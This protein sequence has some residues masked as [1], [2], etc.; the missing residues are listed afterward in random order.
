MCA[1][2]IAKC[3]LEMLFLNADMNSQPSKTQQLLP[4]FSFEGGGGIGL[5]S[6]P[7]P[8]IGRPVPHYKILTPNSKMSAV[9]AI[10][11]VNLISFSYNSA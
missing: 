5:N 11:Q 2:A 7:P 8:P 1:C 9:Q 3:L 10:Y 4:G 6:H